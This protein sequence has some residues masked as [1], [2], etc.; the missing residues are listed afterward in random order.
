MVRAVRDDQD[1]VQVLLL[2]LFPLRVLCHQYYVA[3]LHSDSDA[4]S[5]LELPQLRRFGVRA[6]LRADQCVRLLEDFPVPKHLVQSRL[7]TTSVF[8]LIQINQKSSS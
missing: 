5:L 4:Q 2:L 6:N 1:D 3:T 8:K 7:V